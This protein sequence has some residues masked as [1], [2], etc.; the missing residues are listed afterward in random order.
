VAARSVSVSDPGGGANAATGAAA[1]SR[2]ADRAVAEL[3]R[4]ISAQPACGG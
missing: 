4:W 1:F 2:A 3:A